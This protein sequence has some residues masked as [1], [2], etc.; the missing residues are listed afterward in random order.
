MLHENG[1]V[2]LEKMKKLETDLYCITSEEHSKGRSNIEV[3][4]EMIAAGIKIIQYREKDKSILQ[5]YKECLKIRD[6]TATAGVV[7]I[8]NDNIDIALSVNADGI[9]LGQD[10]L[11]VEKA[12]EIVGNEMIIGI[13]THS[14]QQACEAVSKGADYLGIGP[15]YK[16][17]TKKDVCEPVG[18]EYLEYTVRNIEIPF[19]AIGGIKE[20]NM[21]EVAS[22]GAKCIAMVTEI[23]GAEDIM[24]KIEDIRRKLKGVR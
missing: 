13:S 15:V 4:K 19:V 23:V 9:H 18:L 21:L 12:R 2:Y 3:V 6:L 24:S 7:M 5:K 14:P 11:P 22:R 10:D 8:V 1:G 17:Y 20:H 16:T